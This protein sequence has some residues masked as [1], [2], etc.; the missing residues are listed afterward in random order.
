MRDVCSVV[1]PMRTGRRGPETGEDRPLAASGG[2][3]DMREGLAGDWRHSDQEDVSAI[4]SRDFF[5]AINI[6]E[7]SDAASSFNAASIP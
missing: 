3:G 5:V 7:L 4:L 1:S 6:R 2:F